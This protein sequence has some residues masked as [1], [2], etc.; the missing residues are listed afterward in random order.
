[1]S[2]DQRR[3]AV[4]ASNYKLLKAGVI[5]WDD[6]VTNTRVRSLR[7]VVARKKLTM[8]ALQAAG[9]KKSVAEAAW[10]SVHTTGHE[11]AA[12]HR[13]ALISNLQGAGLTTDQVKQGFARGVA[14][15]VKLTDIPPTGPKAPA[16][17][18]PIEPLIKLLGLD[19]EKVKAAMKKAE[20]EK[21]RREERE[22]K[23]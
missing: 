17:P 19:A 4:G 7:E 5:K 20:E 23:P 6:V 10:S 18:L 9:V 15:R 14:D 12:I 13:K 16:L 1:M 3:E 11:A 22:P 2:E 8:P 21:R